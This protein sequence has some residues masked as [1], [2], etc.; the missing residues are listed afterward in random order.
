MCRYRN[1][2]FAGAVHFV[3]LTISGFRSSG[4]FTGFVECKSPLENTDTKL[5]MYC[6][7]PPRVVIRV[8]F[9]WSFELEIT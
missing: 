9:K 7:K 8:A 5:K 4:S 3:V 1:Q 6:R 2:R